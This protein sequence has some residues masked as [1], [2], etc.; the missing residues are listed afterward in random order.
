MRMG[1]LKI[2]VD[3]KQG[4]V[5]SVT[6]D[7]CSNCPKSINCPLFVN[8]PRILSLVNRAFIEHLT[9]DARARA[10]SFMLAQEE[11]KAEKNVLIHDCSGPKP[12]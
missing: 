7:R 11:G 5:Q 1:S 12:V 6:V 3:I 8:E 2:E 4:K 10:L 9:P